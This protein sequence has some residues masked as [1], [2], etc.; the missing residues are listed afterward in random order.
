ML[1]FSR[2]FHASCSQNPASSYAAASRLLNRTRLYAAATRYA[3]S[4]VRSRPRYGVRRKPDRF[5][6]AEYLLHLFTAALAD[7]IV[8]VASRARIHRRTFFARRDVRRNA[9]V[10][11]LLHEIRAVVAFVAPCGLVGAGASLLRPAQNL[12]RDVCHNDE[13]T[14]VCYQ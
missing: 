10:R 14:N 8:F 9:L 13:N 3:H 12:F 2:T 4:S 1:S 11:Q 6:P 7:G 5:H